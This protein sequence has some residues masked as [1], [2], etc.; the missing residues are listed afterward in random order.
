VKASEL[1]ALLDD[2][3]IT[4]EASRDELRDLD[5]AIGDGDLGITVSH[6]A[7]AVRQS[8]RELPADASIAL[9]LRTAGQRFASANP[10]TMS[11]LVA[12]GLLAAARQLGEVESL[13]RAG[14]VLILEA[15]T[16]AIQTRGGAQLGDKTIVDALHPTI[17]VL[18]AAGP[19]DR[20]ALAAMIDAARHAVAETALLRSQRGRAAWV[21]DRTVGHPDG[22]ATAYLRFLEAIARG[23]PPDLGN[24]D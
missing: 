5:A 14:G 18:K 9:I 11:A 1:R 3:L 15:A 22:G 8:L 7:R 19:D 24:E 23:M 10:S 16:I 21:G 20:A 6:G 2:A 17:E 4:L 13:D 12:S